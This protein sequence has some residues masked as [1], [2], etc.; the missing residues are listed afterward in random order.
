M[1]QSAR[2][3]H[4]AGNPARLR[5]IAIC[6]T[7]I[8]LASGF[9]CFR[10]HRERV[11][12]EEM[13]SFDSFSMGS[14]EDQTVWGGDNAPAEAHKAITALEDRISWRREGDISKLNN[15]AGKQT[16]EVEPETISL[17]EDMLELCKRSGR[18]LDI[19][20]G[21]VTRLWNFDSEPSLPGTQ[22]LESALALVGYEMLMTG[23]EAYFEM[24]SVPRELFDGNKEP[25]DNA[26]A[27]T[28]A[29]MAVDLGAVGK[30][31][32]LDA[33]VK[34]YE[35]SGVT[36]AVIAVGGSVACYGS[37]P[38]GSGWRVAV[39]DPESAGGLG[40]LTLKDGYV[41]TSG[42]YEKYFEQDGKT[43]HHILDPRTG[44]PAESGLVSVTV[45]I[46]AGSGLENPGALSDGLATA[47][48]VLGMEESITLLESYGA[49]AIFIDGEK[50]V[51][52]TDGL[53]DSFSLNNS[54][55]SL[56]GDNG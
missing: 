29:G 35:S 36:R 44:Y 34:V 3:K 51:Y 45:Y 17:L 55:Y 48:F 9:W 39:R 52:V 18:A 20:L 40:V 31:A 41:S 4:S 47:C 21:P 26:A 49:E 14:M 38:D 16:V 32:A 28:K 56:G 54:G 7:L 8:L 53:R 42:S 25:L 46:P 19:T 15:A 50:R 6:L 30:G 5:A 37:K 24:S 1:S 10:A 23:E 13:H 12:R 43:Y 22:K 33:A 2:K 11:A 27:L